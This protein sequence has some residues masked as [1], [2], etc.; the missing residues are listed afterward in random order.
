MFSVAHFVRDPC[1]AHVM[2][3]HCKL[4]VIQMIERPAGDKYKGS[5]PQ[6]YVPTK[7]SI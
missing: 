2:M 6:K 1:P 3:H 4:N 5:I 7:I